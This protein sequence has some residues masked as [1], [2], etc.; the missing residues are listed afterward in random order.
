[1]IVKIQNRRGGYT[2][3]DPSK[4]LPGEFA[5]VQTDDPNTQSGEAIYI[6]ITAGN[7]VRLATA[8]E[9]A[10]YN[11]QSQSV[12]ES[13]VQYADNMQQALNR[14]QT[15]IADLRGGVPSSVRWA[16]Y[17][18][19]SKAAY[20]ETGLSDELEVVHSWVLETLSVTNVLTHCTTNNSATTV[21]IGSSYTAILT[22]D[23]NY[24]LGSVTVTMGGVD[25][26]ATVYS[27]G[28]ITIPAVTGDIVITATAVAAVS[29]LSAVYT[30]SGTI[31]DTDAL[32]ILKSDLVV[33]ATYNDSSTATVPSA[34]YTLSGTLAAGTSTVTVA[35]GGITTTF[36]VTVTQLLPTGYTL[37]KWVEADGRQYIN[38]NIS[39]TEDFAAEYA[40]YRT[41]DPDAVSGHF[42]SSSNY[43]YPFLKGASSTSRRNVFA[44]KRAGTEHNLTAQD[45]DGWQ[46]DTLYTMRCGWGNGSDNAYVD[47]TVLPIEKGSTTSSSNKLYLFTY[48]GAPTTTKYRYAGRFYY[49]KLYQNNALVHDFYPCKN[50]S[51]V[52]GIYDKTTETFYSSGSGTALIAGE[53]A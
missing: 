29:S 53:V 8:E 13:V 14:I 27:S 25:I 41:S 40:I 2:D 45:W 17:T 21:T 34:D 26:T 33:T 47:D 51:D 22:A 12:Y 15:I 20:I 3:Y 52:V 16:I 50:A 30:Q 39:E 24:W 36:N 5:V 6:A 23:T 31:Y 10:A 32:D 19:L 46:L 7:V 18:L 35:Y 43:Y 4:L 44:A 37:L 42:M 48:G 28:T 38:T 1:M 11:E 49:M 9:I